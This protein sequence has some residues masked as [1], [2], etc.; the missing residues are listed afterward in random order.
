MRISHRILETVR[1]NPTSVFELGKGQRGS[2]SIARNWEYKLKPF[3]VPGVSIGQVANT[4]EAYCLGA[5]NNN[6]ANLKKIGELYDRYPKYELNYQQQNL[7]FQDFH[8]NIEFN[9]AGDFLLTGEIFRID[10]TRNGGYA[11]TVVW[12]NQ[13]S[14]I[15]AQE[16][17]FPVLQ[18]F[19]ADEFGV[20]TNKVQV[21]IYDFENVSHEYIS[22]DEESIEDAMKELQNI[23]KEIGAATV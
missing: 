1:R 16:L 14:D 22:F 11:I 21:G 15:W 7:V 2:N 3:H 12:K 23:I 4:F 17:R 6:K 13:E 20:P 9:I 5:F 10:R 19:Y 8:K 18:K